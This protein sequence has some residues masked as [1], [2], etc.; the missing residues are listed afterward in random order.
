VAGGGNAGVVRGSEKVQKASA[1]ARLHVPTIMPAAS[2]ER[3]HASWN[4]F[5]PLGAGVLIAA[6]TWSGV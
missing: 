1:E 4:V 6:Q 2:S 5:G 3:S